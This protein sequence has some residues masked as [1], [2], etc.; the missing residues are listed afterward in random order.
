MSE[1]NINWGNAHTVLGANKENKNHQICKINKDVDTSCLKVLGCLHT[2]FTDKIPKH[3]VPGCHQ[4]V[5]HSDPSQSV[6]LIHKPEN[7]ETVIIGN[8][9]VVKR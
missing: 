3:F 4:I 6:Q 8:I 9:G 7:K 1:V 2:S 5:R